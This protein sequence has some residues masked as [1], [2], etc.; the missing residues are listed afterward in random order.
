MRSLAY[1]FYEDEIRDAIIYETLAE[2]EKDK[3]LKNKLKILAEMERGHANFWKK[4]LEKRGENVEK[5]KLKKVSVWK[6]I[7]FRKILGLRLTI[8]LLEGGERFT[9]KKYYEFYMRGDLSKEEREILARI[10]MDEME[11]ED[12]FRKERKILHTENIR[13]FVLGMNDG[14]VEILG[15]ATGLSAVYINR[16]LLVGLSGLVVGVAGALSMAIGTYVSVRTQRQVNEEMAGRMKIIFSVSKER[17]KEEMLSKLEDD[18]IDREIAEEIADKISENESAAMS[19]VRGKE[20]M[21]ERRAALYTG[22]AYL[23]GVF[24]PVVPYFIMSTTILALPLSV[25][26]AGA[27]LAFVSASLSTLSGISARRKALEMIVMG[28]GAAFI[29]YLFG[30]LINILFGGNFI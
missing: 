4:Y 12:I 9:I 11:H 29:S 10:I 30:N 27:T 5:I 25:I 19:M 3:N 2:R 8:S 13:D 24:F 20:E 21:S 14:L 7:F 15:A 17:A 23:I 1:S 22:I 28:L 6:V 26:L 16:P 18:G